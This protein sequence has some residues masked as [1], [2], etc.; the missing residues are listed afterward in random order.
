M[1]ICLGD[2]TVTYLYTPP[3]DTYS[4]DCHM[5]VTWPITVMRVYMSH[6]PVLLSRDFSVTLDPPPTQSPNTY[7][8]TVTWTYSQ[9]H[10]SL[11]SDSLEGE[12]SFKTFLWKPKTNRLHLSNISPSLLSLVHQSLIICFLSNSLYIPPS[13]MQHVCMVSK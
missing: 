7:H 9:L 3:L 4:T 10:T 13:T 6:E 5:T 8:T 11:S 1:W 2:V 12:T